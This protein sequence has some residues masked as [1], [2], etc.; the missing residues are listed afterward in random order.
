MQ[1]FNALQKFSSAQVWRVVVAVVTTTCN[2]SFSRLEFFISLGYP[3]LVHYPWL[4]IDFIPKLFSVKVKVLGGGI[5]AYGWV[6]ILLYC[7][8]LNEHTHFSNT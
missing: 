3:C 8:W 5:C 4:A 2:F 6:T 7:L 1:K